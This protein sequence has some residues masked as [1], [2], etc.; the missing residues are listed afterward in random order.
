MKYTDLQKVYRAAGD[1]LRRILLAV[2]LESFDGAKAEDVKRRARRV[3]TYLN[4]MSGRWSRQMTRAAY[5]K[6]EKR[7]RDIL[8]RLG[9]RIPRGPL[10]ARSG[11]GAV[12][13]VVE[14]TI[15]KA[16]GSIMG[17]I[18]RYVS[19]SLLAA[20][21]ARSAPL[22]VQEFGYNEEA[23]VID[24]LA[25]EAV[26]KEVSR[27]TLMKTIREHLIEIMGD[28]KYIMITGHDGVERMYDLGKYAKMVARTTL[29]ESQTR[30][31][32]DLCSR[33]ENDLVEV[34]SHGTTCEICLPY[35]GQIYSISGNDPKYPHLEE[36][37]PFHPNCAH[38]ILPTSIEEIRVR[39]REQ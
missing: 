5:A 38:S 9:R 32:L 14:A 28:R 21:S 2:D 25:R 20:Q 11:P 6:A 37:T 4:A 8:W 18:E 16:T 7:T 15:L 1:E 36:Q 29:R 31:T 26:K 3:V 22:A 19:V 17:T 34:S 13:E 12:A 30:A 27:K 35:E 24:D 10:P 33:Y 39:E 23:E